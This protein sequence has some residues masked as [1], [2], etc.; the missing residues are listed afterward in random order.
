MGKIGTDNS[1]ITAVDFLSK[2][3]LGKYGIVG[4]SDGTCKSHPCIYVYS[5]RKSDVVRNLLPKQFNS[6]QILVKKTKPFIPL[7]NMREMHKK[8]SKLAIIGGIVGGLIG[9][10]IYKDKA[11][12]IAAT[13]VFGAWRGWQGFGV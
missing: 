13:T 5:T 4:I 12:V 6:Y 8:R 3:Y 1:L 7:G 2:K 11:A 9:Y 10:L